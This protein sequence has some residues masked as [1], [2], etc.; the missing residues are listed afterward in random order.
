MLSDKMKKILSLLLISLFA[1]SVFAQTV[2][3]SERFLDKADVAYEDGDVES[4]FKYI[5]QAL[6]VSK[7]D[8]DATNVIAYAQ[9]IYKTRLEQLKKDY[10]D[11]LFIEVK[12]NLEQFP[13]VENATIKKLVNQIEGLQE[14][15]KLA[16]SKA[17]AKEQTDL[18]RKQ[19]EDNKKAQE[20]SLRI[21]QQANEENRRANEESLRLQQAANEEV[22][23]NS[24]E[25]KSAL[26]NGLQDLG[27]GFEKSAEATKGAINKVVWIVV[28][29]VILILIIVLVIV[30]IAQKSFKNQAKQ[31]EQYVQ[32]F[33]MLAASQNQTNRLMLGGIT[34]LYANGENGQLRLAGSSRWAPA[35]LPDV[36][37][38]PE[39]QEELRMLASKCEEIG[40][41]IDQVTARKNNSKNVS[42]LV[43]KIAIQLGLPQGESML[44]FCAAMIYDAGFLGIDPEILGAETL[45]PEQKDLLREHVNM[46][47]KHLDFVPK[48]YWQVFEDAARNHHE[49]MD[50]SGYPKKLKGDNIPQIA[51]LI[52]VCESYI[53]MISKRGYR[54]IM[55]KETAIQNLREQPQFYDS[56][57]I[58]V[59]EQII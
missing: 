54:A 17:Q 59:L 41:R 28:L 39:E 47:D 26:E 36:E 40:A 46:A 50:G 53:S 49:N 1:V 21:Q 14:E 10:D 3:L 30:I 8:A 6:V 20:E 2:S 7:N 19:A 31:Q 35:A 44:Y 57:V 27:S 18:I 42:E 16:E 29:I 34:D 32:A 25:L 56:D 15:K 23:K 48:K 38:S 24:Q 9:T 58:D 45:T 55:D 11:Q 5:N 52:R 4:A 13:K 37:Q 12:A 51:R 43:Y 33:R 22:R